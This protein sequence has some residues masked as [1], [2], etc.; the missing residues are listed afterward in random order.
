MKTAERKTVRDTN[1][2][3]HF[4]FETFDDGGHVVIY[5]TTQNLWVT[6]TKGNTFGEL[7]V[8]KQAAFYMREKIDAAVQREVNRFGAE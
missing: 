8:N 3:L 7:Q 1:G 6:R 5:R 2:R 4:I